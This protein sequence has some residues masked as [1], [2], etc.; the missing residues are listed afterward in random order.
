MAAAGMSSLNLFTGARENDIFQFSKSPL[1]FSVANS[2]GNMSS[3][4]PENADDS[5]ENEV[6]LTPCPILKSARKTAHWQE[7]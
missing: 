2:T 4:T 7:R 5:S 1:D 3:G 6:F